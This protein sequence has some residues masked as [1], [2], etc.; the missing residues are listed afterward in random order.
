ME[1]SQ[2]LQDHVCVRVLVLP[3]GNVAEAQMTQCLAL[4]N[5]F[6]RV[7]LGEVS[8]VFKFLRHEPNRAWGDFQYHRRVLALIGVAD[9]RSAD[10][11]LTVEDLHRAVHG[12]FRRVP[13]VLAARAFVFNPPPNLE[14]D[15]QDVAL[16]FARDKAQLKL[17]I[18]TVLVD[19]AGTLLG[20][21]QTQIDVKMR[22]RLEKP[23][24][25]RAPIEDGQGLEETK[26]FGTYRKRSAA[27]LDK[28]IG[29]MWLVQNHPAN[30]VAHFQNSIKVLRDLNDH[31]WLA[32][33]LE[34]CA[35]CCY[36]QQELSPEPMK[37]QEVISR[38]REAA[39]WLSRIP[40]AAPLRLE[41]TCKLVRFSFF[42]G[43]PLEAARDI[44]DV[45]NVDV[46]L[47]R[48][49][50]VQLA[51]TLAVLCHQLGFKRKGAYFLRRAAL[52]QAHV[53]KWDSAHQLLVQA[54]EHYGLGGLTGFLEPN[55]QT[56]LLGARPR[57]GWAML[58]AILLREIAYT[59]R[60]MGDPDRTARCVAF[61]SSAVQ[62]PSARALLPGLLADLAKSR[63]AVIAPL[64]LQSVPE[65]I[66][67]V[68]IPL[69]DDLKPHVESSTTSP[70]TP[71]IYSPLMAA[72]VVTKVQ[73]VSG[74]LCTASVELCNPL[75]S[76]LRVE[77]MVLCYEGEVACDV[78]PCNPFVL[79]AGCKGAKV[80]LFCKPRRP[81]ELE[82]TGCYVKA[83]NVLAFHAC[84]RICVEVLPPLPLLR[85]RHQ[86]SFASPDAVLKLIRGEQFEGC[87]KLDNEGQFA[88][89]KLTVELSS[90]SGAVAKRT[91]TLTSGTEDAST[92]QHIGII[93]FAD[94]AFDFAGVVRQLPLQPQQ[95][96]Q[97]G[98]TVQP[99]T[100]S[101]SGVW[102][103]FSY[104]AAASKGSR[105]G[106]R[107][108]SRA[109]LL[110]P[111]SAKSP[112]AQ[113]HMPYRI[114]TLRLPTSVGRGI[115]LLGFDV[116]RAV[117]GGGQRH[118]HPD[119]P[120]R[121]EPEDTAVATSADTFLV[122]GCKNH[123]EHQF[124]L[125]FFLENTVV[126]KTLIQGGW[127]SR[128][129][130]PLP[131]L[132]TD[133]ELALRPPEG[134]PDD[135]GDG[136]DLSVSDIRDRLVQWHSDKLRDLY[137]ADWSLPSLRRNGALYLPTLLLTWDLLSQ[138]WPN[139]LTVT[140]TLEDEQVA[141]NTCAN[142][143]VRV[144]NWSRVP[145]PP[146]RLSIVPYQ[147]YQTGLCSYE[148]N[149]KIGVVGSLEM[150]LP[151]LSPGGEHV[152][153]VS[154][155]CFAAGRFSVAAMCMKLDADT[156]DG[157]EHPAA[158]HQPLHGGM[159]P[160]PK[161]PALRKLWRALVPCIGRTTEPLVF[162][163]K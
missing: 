19:L 106:S 142:V 37:D 21:L 32:G 40:E 48:P 79:P 141:T 121:L 123:T 132:H 52:A 22:E 43:L 140:A 29:D 81:G 129:F 135:E 149:G 122:F 67:L 109:S 5:R 139:H 117:G 56:Q 68:A 145:L 144:C 6:N 3:M 152:H 49:D 46:E 104:W 108:G 51:G 128:V 90:P 126:R 159:N 14:S 45:F 85:A 163:V 41:V 116:M 102:L 47:D 96:V 124:E 55:Q 12:M 115:Q 107:G 83:C 1:L 133:L 120:F 15:F 28:Q 62:D 101:A 35:V 89:D 64:R 66:E 148:L 162:S 94:F 69:D 33:A 4:L 58:Q 131:P 157:H 160:E 71:F 98:F 127:A 13:T 7:P 114:A 93:A 82:L 125:T 147:D 61:F 42:K 57:F 23:A 146:C 103:K 38:L 44:S 151:S 9:C 27:R 105:V 39:G 59:A 119:S 92:E 18:E 50:Q 8:I 24:M 88:V 134:Q 10:A 150:L 136:R 130:L 112:V 53:R 113:Q 26:M 78:F 16:L 76:E 84:K 153:R 99:Q 60:Q 70:N 91:V 143:L 87:I 54:S 25:L 100:R 11:D 111:A 156:S 155:V 154:L 161:D 34:G 72:A 63:L 74:E 73:W 31:L 97:L 118:G 36:L 17:R 158:F 86:E 20:A 77:D 75:P 30:A 2:T 137:R 65:V 95:T 110:L 138:V 80:N